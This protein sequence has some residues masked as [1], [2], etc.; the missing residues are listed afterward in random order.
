M[1]DEKRIRL[2]EA[3]RPTTGFPGYEVSQ[4]GLV[5]SWRHKNGRRK[6]P[7]ILSASPKSNGYL[8]VTLRNE[9]GAMK[10]CSVH[11][12]VAAAF[13]PETGP[14]VL[15]KDGD[16]TNNSVWNLKYGDHSENAEDAYKHGALNKGEI[17]YKSKLTQ[18]DVN[19]IRFALLCG[20]TQA[21]LA[22]QYGVHRTTISKIHM[23]KNWRRS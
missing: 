23:R 16:K 21:D 14:L 18:A 20:E 15:H 11:R 8:Q 10:N 5:R 6:K 9:H 7:Y 17:H 1:S 13:L 12:L 22:R 3:W 2:A 4:A 19:S